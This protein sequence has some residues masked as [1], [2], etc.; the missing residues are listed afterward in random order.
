MSDNKA[1]SEREE[2]AR[3][4]LESGERMSAD[5]TFHFACYPGISCFN[6]CCADVNIVL[7]PLDIVQMSRALDMSTSDFLARHTLVPFTEDQKLPVVFL[8]MNEDEKRTC[9][10]VTEKGCSIYEAR[11]WPCRMYPL[12]QAS[13][14]DP[15]TQGRGFFF[16]M[17][18]D[19]CRG[20]EEDKEWTAGQWIEDQGADRYEESGKLFREILHHP[21]LQQRSLD[22]ARM[23]MFYMGCYDLDKFRRFIFESKFLSRFK[24]SDDEL[25]AVRSS[26]MD[27]LRFAFRWLK[28]ALFGELTM[29]INR[30][31]LSARERE[32]LE[33]KK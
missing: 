4:I 17:K 1:I 11:P 13:P 29:E 14:A 7:T 12:G 26:D 16:L 25:N 10:F 19:H 30:D 27:A 18:E 23:E 9:P 31:N 22:P 6:V 20:F 21:Y 28:F 5:D 32:A 15:D 2:V 33:K 8:R 24:V 3:K